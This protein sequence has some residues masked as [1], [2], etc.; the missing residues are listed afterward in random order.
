LGW[1]DRDPLAAA[2]F[3]VRGG[4]ELAPAGLDRVGRDAGEPAAA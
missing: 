3:E 2:L 4:E 1:V